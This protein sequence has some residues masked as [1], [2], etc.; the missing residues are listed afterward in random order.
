VLPN[1]DLM[2]VAWLLVFLH[3]W[4][5]LE[6]NW[7]SWA[8]CGLAL[9][10]MVGTKILGLIYL[11]PC[12]LLLVVKQLDLRRLSAARCGWRGWSVL[13][14]TAVALGGFTYFRNWI[15]TGNPIYPAIF[16]L[17]GLHVFPG[18]FDSDAMAATNFRPGTI[19][20]FLFVRR[21]AF[22]M[23]PWT[24]AIWGVAVAATPLVWWFRRAER[25]PI[26]LWAHIILSAILFFWKVPY[27]DNRLVFP[28]YAIGLT[29]VGWLVI[30]VNGVWPAW[31]A[32]LMLG[33][34]AVCFGVESIEIGPIAR[35]CVWASAVLFP[36]L[37]GLLYG[38]RLLPPIRAGAWI[39]LLLVVVLALAA[40][41][42]APY[43]QRY[44]TVKFLL[45]PPV[46]PQH[47]PAWVWLNEQTRARGMTVTYTGSELIYPLF[48]QDLQND[49]TYLSVE[50]T[51][52]RFLH[53]TGAPV[54]SGVDS[55][56]AFRG[57]VRRSVRDDPD[58]GVWLQRILESSADFL[59]VVR[60]VEPEPIELLWAER[61]PELFSKVFEHGV[62][63]IYRVAATGQ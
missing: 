29:L 17:F 18:V 22:A 51:P 58:A 9:G 56:L 14:G 34:I 28:T 30:R 31:G 49:V 36:C 23:L 43:V 37:L 54:A 1:V 61:Q 52:H 39:A 21:D 45:Y 44:Q 27:L 55:D 12:L 33:G 32:A 41:V 10:M 57:H 59:V 25:E 8:A 3:Y 20:D 15:V 6:T 47:G 24:A 62:V 40:F 63:T 13:V 4:Q 38:R 60:N 48:G 11:A 5:R 42:W 7:R 35:W 46:Y 26:W 16:K 50:K 19:F 2:I 53:E